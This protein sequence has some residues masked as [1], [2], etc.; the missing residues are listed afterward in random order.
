MNDQPVSIERT[1]N[2][3]IEKV[4]QAIT[5]KEQMKQ[6]YFDMTNFEAKVGTEFS[7]DGGDGNKIYKHL[8]KITELNPEKKLAYSW[9]YDGYEGISFVSF[10]LFAEENKTRLKLTHSGLE[11]FPHD[12][13]A[14][15]KEDF[16]AGWTEII[17]SKLLHFLE[18]Q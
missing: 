1:F 8:C 12:N 3:P 13:P 10:E 16:V 14:F 4:W 9:R 2:A 6:W 15:A 7:F 11:T 18:G 5:D 17:G